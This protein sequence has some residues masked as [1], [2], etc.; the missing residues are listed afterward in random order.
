M[1]KQP[2][3]LISPATQWWLYNER[4]IKYYTALSVGIF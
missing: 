2:N 4:P 3:N 1:M